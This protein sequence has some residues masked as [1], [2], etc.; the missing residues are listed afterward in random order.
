MRRLRLLHYELVLVG[1]GHDVGGEVLCGFGSCAGIK[2]EDLGQV[3]DREEVLDVLHHVNQRFD[4]DWHQV[5]P[6]LESRRRAFAE[7]LLDQVTWDLL[8][9]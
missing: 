2:A 1:A 3:L 6:R 8:G 5:V 4:L 9:C 7:V